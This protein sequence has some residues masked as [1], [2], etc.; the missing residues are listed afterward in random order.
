M[1]AAEFSLI[2]VV[3]A[4]VGL[5]AWVY[6][7]GNRTRLESYGAMPLDDDATAERAEGEQQ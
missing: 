3:C 5:T 2:A 7:P 1:S 4:F 6:W